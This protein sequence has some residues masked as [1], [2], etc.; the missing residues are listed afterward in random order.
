MSND[1]KQIFKK[2]I[3]VFIFITLLFVCVIVKIVYLQTIQG[4]FWRKIGEKYNRDSIEVMA[5]RGNI[6]ACNGEL[7]ATSVPY[8]RLYIDFGIESTEK[9]NY[10]QQF[11]KNIDSLS[12]CLSRKLGDKSKEEYKKTLIRAYNKRTKRGGHLRHYPISKKYVSYIELQE[13]KKFPFFRAGKFKSG[14]FEE[15]HYKR[16]KPFGILAARTIGNIY[17]QDTVN[18]KNQ[19]IKK[20]T[21]KFGLEASFEQQ[22]KGTNGIC[23]QKRHGKRNGRYIDIYDVMPI[24]GNDIVTTI[25]IGIQDAAETALLEKMRSIQAERG[26]A[27][28]M[29]VKTGEIKAIVNLNRDENGNYKE[30]TNV[31]FTDKIEPGSTFKTASF[32]VAM[33]DGYLHPDDLINTTQ[34]GRWEYK[35]GVYITDSHYKKDGSGYGYGPLTATQVLTKSSNIGTA[36]IIDSFYRKKPDIFVDKIL[37][38]GFLTKQDFDIKTGE[39]FAPYCKHPNDM[40]NWDGTSLAWLSFGYNSQIPP[41]YTLM[42]YNAIANDGK[43]IKPFLVKRITK[44]SETIENFETKTINSS[45]CSHAT[46]SKI[47]AMLEAVVAS[48]DGTGYKYVRS[49]KVAIAGKTGTAQI[50][51]GHHLSFCGYFPADNPQYSCI[52]SII[53]PKLGSDQMS[54]GAFSGAVFKTIA[55]KIYA[56]SM[57]KRVDTLKTNIETK[58]PTTKG[59]AYKDIATVLDDID[60]DANGEA[61]KNDW[62]H[63]N[64]GK[65]EVNITSKEFSDYLV[66]NVVGMGARDAVFLM[67]RRG[68]RVSLNGKGS[69]WH[70]SVPPGTQANGQYVTLLLR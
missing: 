50:K 59:G 11:F 53:N 1:S 20:F 39:S 4:N 46:L 54:G 63:T 16:V 33:E 13:I 51:G 36:K 7:L 17:A 48:E 66:P 44:N 14:L 30:W 45:I 22:L 2:F 55:E 26:C 9:W 25:D 43:M 29:E 56:N 12:L 67:E 34:E 49:N 57:F 41:I 21:G 42:F 5:N 37:N 23:R 18:S 69:V 60:I 28:V 40:G 8:Y 3:G 70:Q 65:T 47:R 61:H 64:A 19:N 38:L 52:V 27:I 58:A 62:V 15:I 68:L 6:Y 32:I 10:E 35:R 24:D 31:A